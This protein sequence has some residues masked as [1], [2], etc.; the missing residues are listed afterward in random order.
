VLVHVILVPLPL[1][2]RRVEA[3]FRHGKQR[4]RFLRLWPLVT[5][6][7]Q[8]ANEGFAQH[9]TSALHPCRVVAQFE[10]DKLIGPTSWPDWSPLGS[11]I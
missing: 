4:E 5:R 7:L 8:I 3:R 9:N 2:T 10:N 6:A 1:S 11:L